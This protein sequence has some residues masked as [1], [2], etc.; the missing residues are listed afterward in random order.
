MMNYDF[1]VFIEPDMEAGGYIVT[2]PTLHGCY[3]QGDT[4]E[5]ALVNI[6]E[7]IELCI[8]DMKEHNETLP[9]TSKIL[10]GSVMVAA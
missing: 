9:D 5:E 8:E 2:C 10:I 7:A 3:S 4:I 6:K 1:K